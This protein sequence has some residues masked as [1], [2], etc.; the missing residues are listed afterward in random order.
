MCQGRRSRVQGGPGAGRASL[1]LG[2]VQ[3]GQVAGVYLGEEEEEGPDLLVVGILPGLLEEGL[4][5][6]VEDSLLDLLVEDS[7][8]DLPEVGIL[9]DLLEVGSHLGLLEVGIRPGLP[10]EGNLLQHQGI[11]QFLQ[12]IHQFL[13][14][15][16][17]HQLQGIQCLLPGEIHQRLRSL[18]QTAGHREPFV[19]LAVDT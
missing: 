4:D 14:L 6:L 17:I 19:L 8:P 9:L 10:V 5:L 3:R 13:Q 1:W 15:Q 7:L 18:L 16:E 2:Q 12:G 11:L